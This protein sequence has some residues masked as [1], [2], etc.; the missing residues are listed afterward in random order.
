[1]H[2]DV[3]PRQSVASEPCRPPCPATDIAARAHARECARTQPCVLFGRELNCY[4]PV[5][6]CPRVVDGPREPRAIVR[7]LF[8][9][10]G[11]KSRNLLSSTFSVCVQKRRSTGLSKR[12]RHARGETGSR[13]LAKINKDRRSPYHDRRSR[14]RRRTSR[15]ASVISIGL[16]AS[17]SSYFSFLP[18]SDHRPPMLTLIFRLLLF[19]FFI[20]LP[21]HPYPSRFL[22]PPPLSS[23]SL[24]SCINF[25]LPFLLLFL[26][27]HTHP[28][29][30]LLFIFIHPSSQF[31]S[32]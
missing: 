22:L 4:G 25:L 11:G 17:S 19:L 32:S 30:H 20:I 28:P 23:L 3:L 24:S 18:S 2:S 13:L 15:H 12:D 27:H 14:R 5:H 7:T 10:R 8:C 29:L 1:M 26:T 31:T 16:R 6:V 21:P 9:Q